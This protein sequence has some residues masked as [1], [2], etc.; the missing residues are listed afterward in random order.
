MVEYIIVI[1]FLHGYDQPT[2]LILFEPLQMC[3]DR[4]AVRKDNCRLVV[5][6]L[7]VKEKISAFI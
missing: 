5:F 4:I 3:A 6:S 2:V 7:D 1:Q